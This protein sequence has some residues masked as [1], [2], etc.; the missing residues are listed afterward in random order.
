MYH[1]TWKTIK[2]NSLSQNWIQKRRTINGWG[3]RSRGRYYDDPLGH[4][5]D[6]S[7]IG[8]AWNRK[9]AI[10]RDV[11]R[12][13]VEYKKVFFGSSLWAQK[14]VVR[15]AW[16]IWFAKRIVEEYLASWG[17]IYRENWVFES[18]LSIKIRVADQDLE[19]SYRA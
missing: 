17:Q 12:Y 5:S 15:L 14:I 1:K 13:E 3:A 2:I 7:E 4:E 18:Y 8:W 11:W 6:R 9:A 10:H 16:G 19:T